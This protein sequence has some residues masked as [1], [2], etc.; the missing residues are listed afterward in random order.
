[1]LSS[2]SAQNIIFIECSATWL[3]NC[4]NS[5][6]N[7]I[8]DRVNYPIPH[9]PILSHNWHMIMWVSNYMY[10]GTTFCNWIHTVQIR[11]WFTLQ[12][13]VISHCPHAACLFD[14]GITWMS[15]HSLNCTLLGSITTNNYLLIWFSSGH[16]LGSSWKSWPGWWS[17]IQRR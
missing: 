4:I 11:I 5:I 9:V 16:I 17:G 6:D 7:K 13:R 3:T 8:L 2:V 15:D 1:M 14:S 10:P 12:L